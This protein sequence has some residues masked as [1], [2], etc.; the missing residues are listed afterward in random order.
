LDGIRV[1]DLTRL[2]PGPF[3]T[4]VL[5]DLGA[6]V[7]KI[8]QP[9]VGDYLRMVPPLVDGTGARFRAVNRGKRSLALDLSHPEGRAVALRLAA[10]ADVVVEGFRPGV[11]ERLGLGFDSLQAARKDILLCSISG[12]GQDG[13]FR[14]RA[15]HDINYLALS[16]LLAEIPADSSG[17]HP[18]PLPVQ[19]ADLVGGGL[20]AVV[21]ILAAIEQ[22]RRDGAPRHLDI[23]MTEGVLALMASEM[24][25]LL[26]FGATSRPAAGDGLLSGGHATYGVYRTADDRFLSV[27][28]LEPKFAGTLAAV[29]GFEARAD[30]ML[31]G[32]E[33]QAELRSLL[34]ERIASRPL[35]AWKTAFADVDACVEPVLSLE[36]LVSHPQH[37]SRGVFR[38]DRDGALSMD[39]PV[40]TPCTSSTEDRR[41]PKLG[42]HT[43][44]LL[45]E[46]GYSDA[47]VESLLRS[48]VAQRD[49]LSGED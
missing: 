41:S 44:V 48:G 32:P 26:A 23:S 47:E 49:E 29:L 2:L 24:A 33:R 11:M 46:A 14:E 34:S 28:S 31:A 1:L 37:V 45:E 18:A 38:H 7:M 15:G 22:R 6:D 4:L 39:G 17:Q 36:E 42:E 8:E 21:A 9:G 43:V 25:E 13:P 5:A 16:G 30:E 10:R 20:Y 3:A 19:V 35:D 12:Y 40:H 27:G